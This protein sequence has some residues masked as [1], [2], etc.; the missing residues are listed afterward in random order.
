MRTRDDRAMSRN[1][2]VGRV[3]RS[4]L[5]DALRI[6]LAAIPLAAAVFVVCEASL[7]E[8]LSGESRWDLQAPLPPRAKSK[9]VSSSWVQLIEVMAVYDTNPSVLLFVTPLE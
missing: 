2:V 9:L 4:N 6:V 5:C 8:Q 1:S 7:T 3:F